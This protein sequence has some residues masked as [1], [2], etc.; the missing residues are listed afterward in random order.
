MHTGRFPYPSRLRR[1]RSRRADGDTPGDSLELLLGRVLERVGE[2]S[3]DRG[4]R[5]ASLDLVD[6][7]L[8]DRGLGDHRLCQVER[9]LAA[10]RPVLGDLGAHPASCEV[11]DR[12]LELR[13]GVARE[14]VQRHHDREVEHLAQH[15]QVMLEIA[16]TAQHRLHVLVLQFGDLAATVIL[17]RPDGRD[18]TGH[19]GPDVENAGGDVQELL[20]AQIGTESG[21]GDGPVAEGQ[22]GTR[23]DRAVAAVGDV[24]EGAAVDEGRGVLEGLDQVGGECVAQQDGHGTGGSDVLRG[25][26]TPVAGVGQDHPTQTCAQVTD[27]GGEAERRHHLAGHDDVEPVLTGDAAAEA[28]EADGDLAQCPVAQIHDPADVYTPH[29]HV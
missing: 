29:I 9:A 7:H 27:R 5:V 4:I 8:V 2:G 24:R 19:M 3:G 23:G 10:L 12:G 15:V 11:G 26:R 1:R 6:H 14:P 16:H 22:G 25:D 18:H 13:I 17:Q 20:R 28:A 21:L